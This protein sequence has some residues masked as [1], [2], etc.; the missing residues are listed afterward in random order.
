MLLALSGCASVGLSIAVAFGFTTLLGFKLNPVVNV[1]P[2]VLIGIGVDDMFVLWSTLEAESDLS[3]PVPERMAKA[4][5]KA[6]VSITITSL[7]DILAFI[8]GSTSQLP[9]LSTFCVFATIGI[10]ADYLLQISFFAAFMALDAMREAK[11]KI[12]CCPCCCPPV[13]EDQL[14]SG[15]CCF[16]CCY[17]KFDCL[18]PLGLKAFMV[19]YYIP[20]LR[21]PAFK[22]VVIL[23][24]L[25]YAG[26]SGWAASNLKQDFQFRWF[27]NDDAM[28][29]STFDIQDQVCPSREHPSLPPP[30]AP[31]L[32]PSGAPCACSDQLSV[33]TL[34][35]ASSHPLRSTF[36]PPGCR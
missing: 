19:K 16:R 8:L 26:F 22:A 30:F 34:P 3:V 24:F 33:L 18:R 27:V 6:G 20:L 13:K 35:L 15:C 31:A 14:S 1:L 12:D 7:T 17:G 2:F 11:N 4:M 25:G 23:G 21:K 28:L 9:A 10:A 5:A 32:R 29:Q 36:R